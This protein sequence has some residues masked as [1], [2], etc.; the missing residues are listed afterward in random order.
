MAKFDEVEAADLV[1]KKKRALELRLRSMSLRSIAEELGSNPMTVRD[2]IKEATLTYLP[3]E[4]TEQLRIQE[5]AKIDADEEIANKALEMLAAEGARLTALGGSTMEVIEAMRRW[6]ETKANLRKQRALM[7]GINKPVLVAH[8]HKVTT[9][10]DAELE[11]LV[12]DLAGGGQLLS[13]PEDV[14]IDNV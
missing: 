14:D 7:L 5:A 10:Y 6:N 8:T 1:R 12:S 13:L 4:E 9:E 11:S 3:E 2:W